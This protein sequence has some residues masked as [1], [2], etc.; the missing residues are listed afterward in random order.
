MFI[1]KENL[2]SWEINVNEKS[3][4]FR[5]FK[6]EYDFKIEKIKEKKL[7]NAFI[8]RDGQIIHMSSSLNFE[9]AANWCQNFCKAKEFLRLSMLAQE[10]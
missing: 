1:E 9:Q 5:S 6:Y 4:S 8:Y 3:T 7:Y 2:L 10:H